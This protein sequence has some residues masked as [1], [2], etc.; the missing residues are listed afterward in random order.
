MAHGQIVDAVPCGGAMMPEKL[1]ITCK[2]SEADG[3]A[4]FI[5][6]MALGLLVA[7]AAWH[8]VGDYVALKK[9]VAAIKEQ[10]SQKEEQ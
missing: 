7:I 6:S 9:D 3:C 4:T 2:S 5:G 10:L 1:E 8:F